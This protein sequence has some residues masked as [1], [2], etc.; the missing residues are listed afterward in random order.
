MAKITQA[1]TAALPGL[2]KAVFSQPVEKGG[3]QKI[4]IRPLL[5]K[6]ERCYQAERFENNKAFHQN[7]T[8]DALIA[9][10]EENIE[11]HFRQALI[12]TEAESRQYVLKRD[13]S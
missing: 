6:G 3:A 12:V 7:F 5:L 2:A 10:A 9:W 4:E 11:G 8:D 1:L 13:G